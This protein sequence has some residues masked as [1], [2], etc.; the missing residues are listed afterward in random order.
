M[1]KEKEEGGREGGREGERERDI[2]REERREE[3]TNMSGLHREEPL[4]KR[5]PNYW[6]GKLR[7][8]GRAGHV[9]TEGC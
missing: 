1:N 2:R 3:E 6:A 5:L 7:V 4:G 8:G 9:G